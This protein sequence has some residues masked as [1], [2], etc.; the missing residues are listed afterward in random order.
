MKISFLTIKSTI[1]INTYTLTPNKN[2]ILTIK[3]HHRNKYVYTLTLNKNLIF[4]HKKASIQI[5]KYLGQ[6]F[7]L[8]P[9]S[10]I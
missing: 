8:Y 10:N 7:C 6:C 1:G 3:K 9:F 4:N 5:S 2:P